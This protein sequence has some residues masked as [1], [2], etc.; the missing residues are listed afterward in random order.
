MAISRREFLQKTATAATGFYIV[1]R[2]VLG[3]GFIPPSDKLNIAVIGV[4]GKGGAHIH[5]LK[6]TENLA[7]FCDVDDR[8]IKNAREAF[9]KAPFYR[10]FR[11]MLEQSGSEI[12]AV[13]VA[14]PDHTHAVITKA[15]MESGKHVYVEKPLTHSIAEARQLLELSRK[16]P[17]LVTQMGNQGASMDC[18][19]DVEDWIKGGAIGEVSKI[20]VWTNR[21]VW[22]QGVPTP[23]AETPPTEVDW[24]LWIGPAAYRPYSSRYMPFK[25]RGWWDF[26][27]GSFGDMGCHLVDTA[28]RALDL[29]SPTAVEASATT[30]W[31]DD[32]HEA[33]FPD[34]CPPSSFVKMDF[35]AKNARP[36]VEM[37]WYDGGIKPMRPPELGPNDPFGDWDGGVLMEGS[38]GKL[39]CGIFGENPQLLPKE[40]M[41]DF[42]P[43][44]KNHR[45][46]M[47]D[48]L[49][50][51]V[52]ANACKGI[53]ESSS[54]FSYAVPLTEA[55]LVGNLAVRSY[56]IK[57]LQPGKKAEDWAPYDYPG[58]IRMLWDEKAMRITN[59]EQANAFVSRA[60]RAF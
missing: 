46:K 49:H 28:F 30:V 4:G 44:Y 7:A 56:D 20:H 13:M 41:Q 32:F 52:W 21:P 55:L 54:P 14:T 22:P 45:P 39:L 47:G 26:G 17:E 18:N 29:G 50:Q 19:R 42:K 58:R 12:D 2:H 34:S 43:N 3:K 8:Q 25:W 1:P 51:Q 53:G 6:D 31:V 27:T 60:E 38:K 5:A 23:A 36:A 15:A 24:N 33:N 37:Y 16:Y 11:K 57:N 9:P 40:R 10:D 59:F 48:I 35:P